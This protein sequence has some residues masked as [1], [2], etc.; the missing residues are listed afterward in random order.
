MEDISFNLF[1][2]AILHHPLAFGVNYFA[3]TNQWDVIHCMHISVCAMILRA[4][5]DRIRS[6]PV[7]HVGD[8]V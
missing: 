3:N 8:N 1:P 2:F 7:M 4:Y 6:V 5:G